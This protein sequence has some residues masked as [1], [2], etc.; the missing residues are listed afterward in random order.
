M[1]SYNITLWYYGNAMEKNRRFYELLKEYTFFKP[2]YFHGPQ[3][4]DETLHEITIGEED[5]D[6]LFYESEKYFPEISII[7][8][9]KNFEAMLSLSIFQEPKYFG[10]VY[11]NVVSLQ[12]NKIAHNKMLSCKDIEKIFFKL[13]KIYDPIYGLLDDDDKAFDL[14]ET[15]D[16]YRPN[17]YIQSLFW[18]NYYGK[19]YCNCKGVKSL[20]AS[21]FCE[22]I[23]MDD[24]YF[25]KLSENCDEYNSSLV[26]QRR[27]KLFKYIISPI[28]KRYLNRFN[29]QCQSGDGTM[30]DEK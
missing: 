17:E 21:D 24:G 11:F 10:S 28:T 14:M 27:K 12:I 7:F 2:N 29:E 6:K 22:S 13:I 15:E 25:V 16:S 26:N 8:G 30:I 23:K 20:I 1:A 19:G 18:G 4:Q 5:V 3:E 9:G